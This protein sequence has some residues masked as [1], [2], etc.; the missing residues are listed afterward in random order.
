MVSIIQQK[1]STKIESANRKS[2]IS[3][4]L[5][6]TIIYMDGCR[7]TMQAFPAEDVFDMVRS[8]TGTKAHSG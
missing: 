4:I 1:I 2:M 5:K 3:S 7:F 8:T 6:D